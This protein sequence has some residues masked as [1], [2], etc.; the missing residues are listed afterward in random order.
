MNRRGFMQMIL[1][2]SAAPALVRA[3]SLMKIIRPSQGL[4][5]P[6]GVD[7][8]VREV[9]MYDLN[10]DAFI[11]RWDVAGDVGGVATRFHVAIVEEQGGGPMYV[12]DAIR[13]SLEV[14]A[15]YPAGT[16]PLG[17]RGN[18]QRRDMALSELRKKINATGMQ[19]VH[20]R[21]ELPG[22]VSH[23]RFL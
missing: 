8:A 2:A 16:P 20:G 17:M 21:L 5:L 4:I 3:D 14:T 22:G 19:I 7:G 12:S 10:R 15:T 9:R 6:L 1:V 18:D 13:G 11:T 23:A